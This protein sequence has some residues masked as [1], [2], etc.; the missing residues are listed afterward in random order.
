[1]GYL[2]RSMP[3]VA[4]GR[5]PKSSERNTTCLAHKEETRFLEE[6]GSLD[7]TSGELSL[8]LQQLTCLGITG[9]RLAVLA[10]GDAR[11]RHELAPAER[12]PSAGELLHHRA[13]ILLGV[14]GAVLADCKA[15]Q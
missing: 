2:P 12:R 1:R 8:H 13:V 15:Q 11:E 4:M 10:G 7:A 6:T 14:Q 9:C 3:G 5:Y